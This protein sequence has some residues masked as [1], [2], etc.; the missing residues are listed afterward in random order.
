MMIMEYTWIYMP[1]MHG[2]MTYDTQWFISDV[3]ST[4]TELM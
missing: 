1:C 3:Y 4:V 2:H